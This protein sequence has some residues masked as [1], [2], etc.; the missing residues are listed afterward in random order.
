MTSGPITVARL[1]NA[2]RIIAKGMTLHKEPKARPIL[3][4]LVEA[5]DRLRSEGDALE[6]AR[7]VL[8]ET[9]N[10]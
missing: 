2:I 6:F 8:E 9:S 4:R 1:N 10:D 3:E 7:R 5:R